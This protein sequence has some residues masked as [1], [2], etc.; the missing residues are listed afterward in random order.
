MTLD[1]TLDLKI[2]INSSMKHFNRTIQI[3][4]GSK[5]AIGIIKGKYLKHTWMVQDEA[6]EVEPKE[7]D[8]YE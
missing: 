2:K 6:N 4:K 7:E 5:K 3:L 1:T 8:I